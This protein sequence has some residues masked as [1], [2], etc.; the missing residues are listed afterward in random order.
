MSNAVARQLVSNGGTI[1]ADGGRVTLTAAA[2]AK[3]VSSVINMDGVI[4]AR[5]VGDLMGGVEIDAQG[6]NAVIGNN[7]SLK[8]QKSGDEQG[9]GIR[10]I[11]VSGYASGQ[12]GGTAQVLGDNVMLLAAQPS[13]PAAMAAAGRCRWAGTSTA[14]GRRP[15]H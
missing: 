8:G 10:A 2:A 9:D 3:V 11:D 1:Q 12:K 6:S 4:Q 7:A 15:R 14:R 13:T 5:T